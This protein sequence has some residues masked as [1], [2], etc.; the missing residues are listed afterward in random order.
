M[1][2]DAR[3][4]AARPAGLVS[5]ALAI[6]A[7]VSVALA[8]SAAAATT[9]NTLTSRNWSG[10]A[11]HRSTV[12]FN[13]VSGR[14]RVPAATCVTGEQAFSSFWVGIGGYALRSTGLEQDGIELDCKADGSQSIS[15][16]YELLPA[17]PHTIRMSV[18]SGDLITASVH[19]SADLVTLKIDDLTRRESFSKTVRDSKAD[20]TSAEW[21][22]EAPE[23][24]TAGNACSVLSLADFGTV[25]F[26]DATATTTTGVTS[27]VSTSRWTTTEL[28]LGY[29]KK[30]SAFV[31]RSPGASATPSALTDRDREFAVT[32]S[33]TQA[34]TSTSGSG[35]PSSPAGGG[36]SGGA[37]DPVGVPNPGGASGDGPGA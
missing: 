22:A 36:N 30:G 21:I 6:A 27:G 13:N 8:S 18:R 2:R 29:R 1:T 7:A 15:A 24:C 4:R 31:A 19:D 12:R 10:Y 17:G 28:L 5:A 35:G 26:S 3:F 11:A 37:S 32:W 34:S 23:E 14:W 33:G 25:R 9:S 16:W 20:D